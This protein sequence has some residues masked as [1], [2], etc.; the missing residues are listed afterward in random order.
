MT[1]P[2]MEGPIELLNHG[3]MHLQ[4]DTEFDTR[5]AMIC[6]DNAVE[7]TMKTY[8]GLPARV[9]GIK[10]ISRKKY[11]E[12][13]ESFPSLLD[14]VEEFA[15]NKTT[16]IELGDVE[17]YH[18]IRNQLYHDGNGITVEKIKV[19]GYAEI[20]KIL[21]SNFFNMQPDE[22]IEIKI[23]SL[24]GEFLGYWVDIERELF[25]IAEKFKIKTTMIPPPMMAFRKMVSR[26]IVSKTLE[27][28]FKN[29]RKFRNE[30]IHGSKRPSTK[31]LKDNTLIVKTILK[32]LKEV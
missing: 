6:I 9:T 15:N 31:D 28:E 22:F 27:E 16:G 10:G 4:Q 14:G 17:W 24:L 8:L 30:L 20:A 2:W 13:S 5:M 26:K 19:E 7:L 12:I 1:K 3:L 23:D 29:A 25:R 21:F 18:R 11:E 32:T